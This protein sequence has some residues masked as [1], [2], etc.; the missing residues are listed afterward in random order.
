MWFTLH[1]NLEMVLFP[2][3]WKGW[4]EEKNLELCYGAIK[5]FQHI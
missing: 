2:D 4:D 5:V 3:S 1:K